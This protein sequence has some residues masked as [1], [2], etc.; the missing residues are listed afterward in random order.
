MLWQGLQSAKCGVWLAYQGNYLL[1]EQSGGKTI[2]TLI[3]LNTFIMNVLNL[4]QRR[5]SAKMF[6]GI[7][8]WSNP[9]I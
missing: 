9:L 4:T 1:P 5:I 6:A 8:M 3:R 2:I 7:A